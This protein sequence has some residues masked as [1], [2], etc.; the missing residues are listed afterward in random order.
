MG[1]IYEVIILYMKQTGKNKRKPISAT[2]I[3]GIMQLVLFVVMAFIIANKVFVSVTTSVTESIQAKAENQA[4]TIE[5]SFAG[6]IDTTKDLSSS[7][8]TILSLY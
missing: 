1:K 6:I 7:A 4:L 5:K 3:L 2:S 8:S